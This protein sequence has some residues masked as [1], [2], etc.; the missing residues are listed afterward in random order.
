LKE[1]IELASRIPVAR[2]GAIEVRAIKE[3]TRSTGK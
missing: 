2:L 1:A 3:L